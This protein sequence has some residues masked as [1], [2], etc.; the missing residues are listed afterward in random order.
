MPVNRENNRG[1]LSVLVPAGIQILDSMDIPFW[2][3]SFVTGNEQ[4]GNRERTGTMSGGSV[5]STAAGVP[6]RPGLG[7]LEWRRPRLWGFSVGYPP[8]FLYLIENK[9]DNPFRP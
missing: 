3:D 9:R 6:G 1:N 2:T 4:E 8:H 7:L 5:W